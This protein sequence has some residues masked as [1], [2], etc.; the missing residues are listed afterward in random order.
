MHLDVSL[1]EC[2]KLQRRKGRVCVLRLL[3]VE[4][5]STHCSISTSVTRGAPQFVTNFHPDHAEGLRNLCER[6][7]ILRDVQYLK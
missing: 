7:C 4:A 5:T 2:G 3:F 1:N 6:A